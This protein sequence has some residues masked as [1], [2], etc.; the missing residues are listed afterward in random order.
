MNKR[1][2]IIGILMTLFFMIISC[3]SKNSP[4]EIL[5]ENQTTIIED[6]DSIVFSTAA[7]KFIYLGKRLYPDP[8]IPDS[9]TLDQLYKSE[10]ISISEVKD[11]IFAFFNNELLYDRQ[12]K[13]LPE[14]N[15]SMFS[16]IY[17]KYYQITIDDDIP[18]FVYMESEKDL[19]TLIKE[20]KRNIYYWENAIIQ[21]TILKFFNDIKIGMK[22]DEVFTILKF[23]NINYNKT[24]FSLILCQATIP[25]KMWYECANFSKYQLDSL[26]IDGLHFSTDSSTIKA[27]LHFKNGDLEYIY[28]DSW[29]GYG[30]KGK[31]R[32]RK[33]NS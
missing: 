31:I 24:N 32:N 20:K 3:L 17:P 22:K 1:K 13:Y 5:K 33:F 15:D 18:Y 6:I 23:P 26:G 28:I 29:I 25:D 27:L 14:V 21:D 4:R 10:I 9:M 11:T 16:F 30:S 8:E 7:E 19:I 12:N 2:L